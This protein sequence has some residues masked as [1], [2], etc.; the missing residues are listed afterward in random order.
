[1]KRKL[2]RTLY[3]GLGGFGIKA[4]LETKGQFIRNYG[5]VPPMIQFLGID[6]DRGEFERKIPLA[7]KEVS[8]SYSERCFIGIIGNPADFA[9][10]YKNELSWIN[11]RNIAAMAAAGHTAIMRPNG[12]LAFVYNIG[13]IKS[14]IFDAF[15][16][17]KNCQLSDSSNYEILDCLQVEINVVF[18]LAGGTGCGIFLDLAYL[19]RKM[20]GR[21][22]DLI[23]YPLIPDVCQDLE[24]NAQSFV[25]TYAAL[26]ELDYLMHLFPED[27]PVTFNWIRESFTEDDFKK[28]P[29]P[30]DCVFLIGRK[31]NGEVF[32]NFQKVAQPVGLALFESSGEFGLLVSTIR[33]TVQGY[34]NDL[35][36]YFR[37]IG[38]SCIS[39]D[40]KATAKRYAD[41]MSIEILNKH[42]SGNADAEGIASKW[43]E[44]V[45]IRASDDYSS[46][47]DS[48]SRRASVVSPLISREE[49]KNAASIVSNECEILIQRDKNH[50][51]G[52]VSDIETILID[53]LK[54]AVPD[55]LRKY[56]AKDLLEILRIIDV[57]VHEC[58]DRFWSEWD[59]FKQNSTHIRTKMD[60]SLDQLAQ[61]SRGL[62]RTLS[63]I[64]QSQY[65][66]EAYKSANEYLDN[67]FQ[68]SRLESAVS[69]MQNLSQQI[70][71]ELDKYHRLIS[72]MEEVRQR[73]Y[74]RLTPVFEDRYSEFDVSD[75]VD[76]QLD[77]DAGFPEYTEMYDAF[78]NGVNTPEELED[79]LLRFSTNQPRYRYYL[80]YTLEEYLSGLSDDDLTKLF[81]KALNRASPFILHKQDSEAEESYH[82]YYFV[83]VYDKDH[84]RFYDRIRQ[85]S[86]VRLEAVSTVD[87]NRIVF[88]TLESSFTL[89]SVDGLERWKELY[90]QMEPRRPSHI[91]DK[92]KE[93]IQEYKEK[94]T[95]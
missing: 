69:L 80:D 41:M 35:R 34:D 44:R 50:V 62:L 79:V 20:F 48:I 26:Q 10:A 65:A 56:G 7:D 67:E 77:N 31:R 3:I 73:W 25:N 39:Y 87:K 55:W 86:P 19:L 14:T 30:F 11:E 33:D 70:L 46:L 8:L 95:I 81:N 84:S 74:G 88:Y 91:D 21:N 47:L 18:S 38:V 90:D 45:G 63:A 43:L 61:F 1:M 66:R 75:S 85:I 72:L 15:S 51:Q 76:I 83:G 32:R 57:K 22:A 82:S 16:R 68:I 42:L 36:L 37:S 49:F 89:D 58:I 2:K 54:F 71:I 9:R 6:T 59:L 27:Q 53:K 5:E 12:R 29:K 92:L 40:E 60:S 52:T 17:V 94:H 4:I 28:S 93:R 78:T 23:A 24:L 13:M 64:H